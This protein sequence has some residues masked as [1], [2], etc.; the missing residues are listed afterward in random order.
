MIRY[1]P[2]WSMCIGAYMPE[3]APRTPAETM[4]PAPQAA[5]QEV[6]HGNVEQPTAPASGRRSSLR[7]LRRQL[8]DDELKQTGVQKLLI[9]GFERAEMECEALRVYIEKFHL[10]DK[11]VAK[12]AE[13]LK[14]NIAL[15]ILSGVGLAGG[16]AIISL[17]TA[18]WKTDATQGIA[19]I[20]V[21]FLFLIGS[22]VARIVQV[23][24]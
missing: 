8:N 11:E 24:K 2:D 16:G 1:F 14:T 4:T 19:A 17:G 18:F 7:D 3:D 10:A 15:D 23:K 6:I 21:G 22:T 5:T 12:L 20:A 9:E 13:K